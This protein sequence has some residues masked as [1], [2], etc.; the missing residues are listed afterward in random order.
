MWNVEIFSSNKLCYVLGVFLSANTV[1]SLA[2]MMASGLVY[3]IA[4]IRI[5]KEELE[6]LGGSR[7]GK[8][9][10]QYLFR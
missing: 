8:K 3:S 7:N 9:S 1:T 6:D 2:T 5:L 4:Q 10:F